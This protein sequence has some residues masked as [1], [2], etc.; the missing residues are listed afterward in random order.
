MRIEEVKLVDI[1]E[2]TK[3]FVRSPFARKED[4]VLRFLFP[5]APN[6]SY[7][8]LSF[9]NYAFVAQEHGENCLYCRMINFL[10]SIGI[11]DDIMVS[12]WW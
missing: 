5:D 2:L 3:E 11:E 12:V 9:D 1:Y 6:D 7:Q 10:Q 4:Q 8:W